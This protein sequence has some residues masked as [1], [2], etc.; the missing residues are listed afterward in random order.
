MLAGEDVETLQA[1]LDQL[2]SAA[3]EAMRF[4]AESYAFFFASVARDAKLRGPKNAHPR[5]KILG[6]LE[7]RLMDADLMLL[8]GLDEMVWPPQAR[9]DAFLNRPMRAALGLT[10]PERKLGQT[11]HDFTQAMGRRRV[12]LSRAQK[13][14]GA[15]TVASR[16]L[17][18][19]AALGD[20][21]FAG[22]A[23]RGRKYVELARLVDR[24]PASAREIKR[25]LPRPPLD[26]RPTSLSVT[27]IET[28]RRDPYALYAELILR[29]V[30]LDPIAPAPGPA[31]AGSA[32]HAALEAFRQSAS[33]R[34][35]AYE[36]AGGAFAPVARR[37]ERKS[38]RSRL[39]RLQLAAPR[40]NDRLLSAL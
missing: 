35:L 31:E 36:C 40:K 29:L 19:L 14:G 39:F 3:S 26:L 13:R 38:R 9:A 18:R 24:P 33:V 11:A 37:A 12:I 30:P 32:I 8:G 22:C 7:A 20:E 2:A 25:P 4:D 34:R 21:T 16:F 5:L 28:L 27:R 6:L 17:Q 23:L 15:P 10:P 1:L